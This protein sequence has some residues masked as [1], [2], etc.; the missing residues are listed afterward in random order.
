LLEARP[1][2]ETRL[3]AVIG[4]GL[5][6]RQHACTLHRSRALERLVVVETP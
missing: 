5:L 1:S 2:R 6:E 4:V 3:A